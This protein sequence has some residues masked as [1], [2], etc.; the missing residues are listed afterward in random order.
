MYYTVHVHCIVL[1]AK[2]HDCIIKI[3]KVTYRLN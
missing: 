2:M 1:S 3:E